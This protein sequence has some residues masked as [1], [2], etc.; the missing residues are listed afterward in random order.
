MLN[1]ARLRA[2]ASTSDSP[3]KC[4]IRMSTCWTAEISQTSLAQ[5]AKTGSL[6]RPVERANMAAIL[7]VFPRTLVFVR[8][9]GISVFKAQTT[10]S[11]SNCVI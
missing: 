6:V 7:S 11:A 4:L 3:G 2:S 1:A 9:V 8:E 5:A 10:L